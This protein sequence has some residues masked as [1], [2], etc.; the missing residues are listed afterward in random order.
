MK[1]LIAVFAA[2]LAFGQAH[3]AEPDKVK[4]FLGSAVV[5][6]VVYAFTGDMVTAVATGLAVGVAKE[7]YDSRDSGTGFSGADL[8]ADGLGVAAG[9]AVAFSFSVA[10]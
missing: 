6:G 10:F 3:G 2:M 8:V 1:K 5:T 9:A 7:L 4:H